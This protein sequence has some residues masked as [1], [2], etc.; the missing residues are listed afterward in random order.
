M[1][2]NFKELES[3]YKECKK[4]LDDEI[5]ATFVNNICF[6]G[7][8]P[9]YFE[10]PKRVLIIGKESRGFSDGGDYIKNMLEAF[11]KRTVYSSND[12]DKRDF[13][14]RCLKFS[15]GLIKKERD[16]SKIPKASEICDTFGTENGISFAFLNI[17]KISNNTEDSE[18]D[19]I[20]VESYLTLTNEEENHFI[21][22]QIEY[23]QPDIILTNYLSKNG[24][25]DLKYISS[26]FY[27][28]KKYDNLCD[29]YIAKICDRNVPVLELYHFSGHKGEEN[30]ISYF[31]DPIVE[32]LSDENFF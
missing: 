9:C 11:H 23:E 20:R 30:D 2:K 17:S 7:H 18:T 19:Y 26:N 10:Q 14:R 13:E 27:L 28:K 16:F 24:R 15:Y 3:E 8:Y 29:K 12:I 32:A 6:D 1:N 21:R 31:W 25:C 22:K 4:K 5:K